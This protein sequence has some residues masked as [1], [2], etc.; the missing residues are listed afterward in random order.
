MRE[1]AAR[2]D[3]AILMQP[4]ASFSPPLGDEGVYEICAMYRYARSDLC[5]LL[6]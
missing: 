1:A 6:L 4:L 3:E 2:R 5:L